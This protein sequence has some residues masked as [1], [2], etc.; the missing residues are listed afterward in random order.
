MDERERTRIRAAKRAADV[1]TV[2]SKLTE[3]GILASALSSGSE[4][5]ELSSSE[6]ELDPRALAL[7]SLPPHIL[8]V[9]ANRPGAFEA[10]LPP[11]IA[12]ARIP[13]AGNTRNEAG[14]LAGALHGGDA[15]S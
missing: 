8:D 9:V 4:S 5:R 6:L 10:V 14:K 15:G 11:F 3:V 7:L 2:K 12:C 13:P 1:A